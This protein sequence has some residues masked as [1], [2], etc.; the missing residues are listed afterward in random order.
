MPKNTGLWLVNTTIALEPLYD[1]FV[2][3]L[4]EVLK[5][6]WKCSEVDLSKSSTPLYENQ[7]QD[8]LVRICHILLR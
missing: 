2:N 8:L 5:F 1:F 6:L 4:G 3:F 7:A